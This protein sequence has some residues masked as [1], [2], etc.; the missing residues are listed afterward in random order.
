MSKYQELN[1]FLFALISP[2][3]DFNSMVYI[4]SV[5]NRIDL[6][7]KHLLDDGTFMSPLCH[8][9]VTHASPLCHSCVIVLS[10]CCVTVASF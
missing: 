3:F 1:D 10:H 8:L 7:A 9:S 5:L 4:M 2:L 6:W